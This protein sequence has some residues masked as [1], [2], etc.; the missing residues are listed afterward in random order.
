MGPEDHWLP[1]DNFQ[2]PP[3]PVVA[4]RT[5][6]TNM[7]L[8]LLANLAAY[9]FGYICAG[10]LLERTENTLQTMEGLERH[11]GHF[12]NWYDTLSLQPL[13]PLY[14]SSVDSGNLA[15]HL[16]TLRPGL[17][18]LPDQKI[19]GA[20]LFEG[21]SDTSRI[22]MDAA[23]GAAPAQLAAIQGDLEAAIRSR[24]TTL[25]AMR[26]CLDRLAKS[27]S[28]GVAGVD[29]PDANSGGQWTGWARALAGQC[30]AALE[31][32]AFLAPWTSMPDSADK[33]T[34]LKGIDGIPTLRELAHLEPEVSPAV[35]H[36]PSSEARSR[37]S[38]GLGDLQRL[39][40]EASRRARVRMDAIERLARQCGE[41]AGMEYDFLY[42]EARNL[43]DCR[44]QRG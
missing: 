41:L 20:R 44:V 2:E 4:H 7:G 37:E 24:P 18:A 17:L 31:D 11:R 10:Q 38:T 25:A 32:L 21:I 12:Y 3:V 23:G 35:A 14:I 30:R 26:L 40:T 39:I 5:S 19:V 27:A 33:L 8:A 13:L 28:E 34:V 15:G 36:R 22:L 6:P 43:L 9:D 29:A 16:L 42:D 1:P